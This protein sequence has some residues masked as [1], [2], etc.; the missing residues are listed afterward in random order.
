MSNVGLVPYLFLPIFARIKANINRGITM[1]Q[2]LKDR[3]GR[4]IGRIRDMGSRQEIYDEY[5]RK[6]GYYDG[7]YTYDAY[8][9]KVGEGN[10]LTAFLHL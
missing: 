4:V 8:G 5:G 3:Y 7:R 9:R 1:D 10:L 6:L 2:T